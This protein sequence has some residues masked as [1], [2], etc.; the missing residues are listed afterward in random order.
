MTHTKGRMLA[1]IAALLLLAGVSTG[2]AQDAAKPAGN[3]AATK[4]AATAQSDAQ[5]ARDYVLKSIA[6][7][8]YDRTR[9]LLDHV[10]VDK[11]AQTAFYGCLCG[12]GAI[13]GS[14]VGFHPEPWGDC[15]NSL[16]CKGGNWGCV[17]F[18]F[19]SGGDTWT[20][21]AAQQGGGNILDTILAN[22]K[23]PDKSPAND[24][25]RLLSECRERYEAIHYVDPRVREL[26]GYEYLANNGVPVLPPPDSIAKQNAALAKLLAAE[27]KAAKAVNRDWVGK[28][29]EAIF[30]NADNYKYVA[31]IAHAAVERDALEIGNRLK[32]RQ[33][34]LKKLRIS[35]RDLGS[36]SRKEARLNALKAEVSE[37]SNAHLQQQRDLRHLSDFLEAVDFVKNA[38]DA[39]TFT[40]QMMSGDKRKIAEGLL[41]NVNIVKGYF[42]RAV[43]AHRGLTD[44]LTQLA[45]KGMSPEEF[46]QFEKAVG[47]QGFLDTAG[48][49]FGETTKAAQWSLDVYDKYQDYKK[50]MADAEQLAKSGRYT[51]AQRNMRLAFEGM[52]YLTNKAAGYMPEGVK[53]LAQFYGEAMKLPG[54]IDTMMR[55]WVDKPDDYANIKGSQ[56]TVTPV[57][58]KFNEKHGFDNLLRDPY[59]F[60]L[61]GLSAYKIDNSSDPRP[62]VLMP[63]AA[64]KPTYISQQTYDQLKEMAY[65]Y[66]LATGERLTDADLKLLG[67]KGTINIDDLRKRA[68]A[69]LAEAGMKKRIADMFG[70]K[71]L[72]N[73]DWKTWNEFS[74]LM[75][76]NLPER[77]EID[78][79]TQKKLL[80]TYAQSP[81]GGGFFENMLGAGSGQTG[82]E[83][84][85][86]FLADYGAK[87]RA[88]EIGAGAAAS[89]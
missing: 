68:K 88:A 78:L 37:L 30:T 29:G 75:R 52:S 36:D 60:R 9:K 82:R 86:R 35:I 72:N 69:A 45:A 74:K 64:G 61:A 1:T 21:C 66:P 33:D 89:E 73:A 50:Y 34:D 27:K 76:D 7:L 44:E 55:K 46:K 48:T 77:C 22:I 47:R 16:P 12:A 56:A 63:D 20:R 42:D 4:D 57:M 18:D 13:M 19:P 24:Y 49:V 17:A 11:A 41:G 67:E 15:Q 51:E 5:K 40:G 31:E 54:T 58:R 53:E 23:K 6:P 59:L 43:K 71:T 32:S 10:G 3:A 65:Y 2:A 70:K 26:A 39:T 14:G 62:Y 25:A 38:H 80:A 28:A 83:T 85:P 84:V 81:E 87:L 79:E 8:G